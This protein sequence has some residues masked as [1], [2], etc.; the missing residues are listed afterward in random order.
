MKIDSPGG[1]TDKLLHHST[2]RVFAWLEY[3]DIYCI[4]MYHGYHNLIDLYIFIV[5]I[6]LILS[7]LYFTIFCFTLFFT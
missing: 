3:D 7:K 2:F 6:G 5:I 1:V 4:Y